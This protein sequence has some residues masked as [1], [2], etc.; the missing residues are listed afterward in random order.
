MICCI[1]NSGQGSKV[2][3]HAK[4]HG[5]RGGT[6]FIGAG[7]VKSKVLELLDIY[8][9]RKE[10]VL[11][12]GE[13]EFSRDVLHALGKELKFHKSHH[14][15]GFCFSLKNYIGTKHHEYNETAARQ[16]QEGADKMYN[17]IFAIVDKGSAEDAVEAATMAGARGGTII[18]ARGS[19]INETNMLF[20]MAIEP[21]KEVV[22]IVAQD[23]ATKPICDAVREKMKID[24]PG[25][26]ILFVVE[27]TD[28]C[29]LY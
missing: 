16:P 11:M 25:N 26:G 18:N 1:V 12:V 20:A 24:E 14:G 6:I 4:Q 29:G 23:E 15:I 13:R 5:I 9:V 8:D 27:L 3:T 22:M 28:V 2:L 21:E 7:T 17:V 19:G 10:I